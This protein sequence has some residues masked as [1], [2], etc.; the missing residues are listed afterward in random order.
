MPQPLGSTP[1]KV[2]RAACSLLVV[3]VCP[4]INF[5]FFLFFIYFFIFFIFFYFFYFFF[6]FFLFQFSLNVLI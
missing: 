1:T 5:L 6:I 4:F 3:V 2:G